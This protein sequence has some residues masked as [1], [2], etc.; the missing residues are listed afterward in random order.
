MGDVVSLRPSWADRFAAEYPD[1]F[2][3]ITAAPALEYVIVSNAWSLGV[4]HNLWTVSLKHATLGHSIS[5]T[6]WPWGRMTYVLTFDTRAHAINFARCLASH[7]DVGVWDWTEEP[8]A[9]PPPV[10]GAA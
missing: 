9:T 1:A 2:D 6:G 5:A 10:G 3:R 8:A 7:L 4:P